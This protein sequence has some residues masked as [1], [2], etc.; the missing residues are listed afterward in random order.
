MK[1]LVL[2]LKYVAKAPN[3]LIVSPQ[4]RPCLNLE[5]R[6]EVLTLMYSTSIDLETLI[7]YNKIS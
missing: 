4:A 6:L 2:E 3:R 7:D 1:A 5:S